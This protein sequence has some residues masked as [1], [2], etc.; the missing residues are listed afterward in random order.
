MLKTGMTNILSRKPR[1]SAATSLDLHEKIREVSH[2]L[3]IWF[4][5]SST[6]FRS[7]SNCRSYT[8]TFEICSRYLRASAALAITLS[9]AACSPKGHVTEPTFESD[10]YTFTSPK[11]AVT[12]LKAAL[13]KGDT[14]ELSRIFGPLSTDI[15]SSGDPV[16]D[17]QSFRAFA[18]RMD[19]N[20]EIIERPNQNPTQKN[21]E[22]AFLYV[23]DSGYPFPIVLHKRANG[24]RF[25]TAVGKEELINRRIGRNEIK[26]IDA[27][28]EIIRAQ[29]R[30]R[31]QHAREGYPGQYA[32]RIVSTQGRRDG[33]FWK[34]QSSAPSDSRGQP[35]VSANSSGGS[36]LP[37]WDERSYYGY[38]FVILKGQGPQARGGSMSYVDDKGRLS[39][40]FG[41]LA[42]PV[43]YGRSGVVTF[44][45]GPDGV[46]YQ[47]NL[48][49]NTG[50]IAKRM[51]RVNPDLSWTPVR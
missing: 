34:S 2:R 39:K 7:R 3:R 5:D 25:D 29:Y 9:S 37:N 40:G 35:L 1:E 21:Q 50:E 48:G 17:Q 42:F 24:W 27:A 11:Q 14:S 20:V 12:T 26:A 18:N 23:G 36:N 15:I 38:R 49:P 30:Y 28:Q 46:L 32:E 31:T 6:P 51:T 13:D 33:L 4:F 44:V 43:K 19:E 41:L 45:A 16:A 47:K 22:L 8:G 10:Q